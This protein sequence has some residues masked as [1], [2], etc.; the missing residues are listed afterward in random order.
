M[1]LTQHNQGF[2][3]QLVYFLIIVV[4]SVLGALLGK[5]N[6]PDEKTQTDRGPR[7]TPP[8]ISRTPTPARPAKPPH[9]IEPTARDASQ[10]TREKI[11]AIL[12]PEIRQRPAPP[13]PPKIVTPPPARPIPPEYV[14]AAA[15][16]DQVE[17]VA[18]PFEELPPVP[19]ASRPGLRRG[20]DTAALQRRLKNPADL[21][22]AFILSEILAPPVGLR[23]NSQS[24]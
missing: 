14:K 6:K 10:I 21:R 8:P 24:V 19:S 23:D 17:I 16:P 11:E 20:F 15:A 7:E 4:L 9:T 22:T 18:E 2:D 13:R 5:K 3:S 12:F 1:W